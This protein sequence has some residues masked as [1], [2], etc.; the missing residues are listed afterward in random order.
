MASTNRHSYFL[1]EIEAYL[2]TITG[3][4]IKHSFNL[5][6]WKDVEFPYAYV[7]LL[8]DNINSE[9]EDDSKPNGE[10]LATIF[11]GVEGYADSDIRD[12]SNELSKKVEYILRE[13]SSNDLTIANYYTISNI[14]YDLM[15]IENVYNIT[16]GKVKNLF[17]VLV[18][19]TYS[20]KYL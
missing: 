17:A 19:I 10:Q 8:S 5:D 15:T 16:E 7:Q 2:D 9:Y 12:I 3:L 11:L 1:A 18:K 4:N 6:K 13:A 20:I 14:D